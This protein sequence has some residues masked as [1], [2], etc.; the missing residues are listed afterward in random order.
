MYQSMYLLSTLSHKKNLSAVSSQEVCSFRR[1][2]K[3]NANRALLEL[4]M[5]QDHIKSDIYIYIYNDFSRF[6]CIQHDKLARNNLYNIPF[7]SR[8][9]R[10]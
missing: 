10:R 6:K 4:L 1:M 7:F 8:C 3:K 9:R 5:K 2:N